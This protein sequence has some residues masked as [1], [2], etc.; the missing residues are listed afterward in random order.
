[1]EKN[2][3]LQ[4][5]TSNI[6]PAQQKTYS[7][8]GRL[9]NISLATTSINSKSCGNISLSPWLLAFSVQVRL[10]LPLRKLQE[11]WVTSFRC[12]DFWDR[13]SHDWSIYN[14]QW[15]PL[16]NRRLLGPPRYTMPEIFSPNAR[17]YS[18]CSLEK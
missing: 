10:Y 8:I 4:K 15:Q 14:I 3:T 18:P 16:T 7:W 17:T 2:W 1:M 13:I 6:E 5:G 9:S 12:N 11:E